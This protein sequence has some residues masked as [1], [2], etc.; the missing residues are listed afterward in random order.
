MRTKYNLFNEATFDAY[1]RAA[2]DNAILKHRMRKRE[3]LQQELSFALLEDNALYTLVY[4]MDLD[5]VVEDGYTVYAGNM[6]IP[7]KSKMLGQAISSLIPK[8]REIIMR[9]YFMRLRDEEIAKVM[10]ISRATVARRRNK[11]V[12]KLRAILEGL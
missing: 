11:A 6:A 1:C 7:V 2:I 5:S 12:E 10:S 3:R 9:Y 4:D 8:D